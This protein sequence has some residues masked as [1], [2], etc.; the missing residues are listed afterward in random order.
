M[1]L[2]V[3]DIGGTNVRMGVSSDGE[4]IDTSTEFLTNPDD[5]DATL[6]EFVEVAKKLA[7]GSPITGAAGGIPGPLI[8]DKSGVGTAP[9][10]PGWHGKLFAKDAGKL[11]DIPFFLENDTA[12]IGIGEAT[13]GAGK[14]YEIVVY[15]TVSTGV[16]GCRVVRG[17]IDESA[18]GFEPGHQVVILDEVQCACGGKGHLE[19]L[20]GGAAMEKR[21]GK[22]P[23]DIKDPQ[24]W[25]TAAF[26]LAIGLNNVLML[27]SPHVF[28]LGGSMMKDISIEKTATYLDDMVA[29][30][31]ELPPIVPAT[32]GPRGG[33]LGGLAI[34]RSH[35]VKV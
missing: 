6:K 23:A 27:W 15:M 35:G 29:I 11:L 34:L 32:L 25:D 3:F 28:V 33:F 7:G 26:H 16:G 24:V 20:I 13:Q 18:R 10:L 30:Y 21:Y 8:E 1:A 14:G 22:K 19:G 17:E 12:T 31:D 2:L 9:N 5:Y 4:T